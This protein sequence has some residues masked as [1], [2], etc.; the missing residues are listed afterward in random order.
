MFWKKKTNRKLDKLVFEKFLVVTNFHNAIKSRGDRKSCLALF[1]LLHMLPVSRGFYLWLDT[2]EPY[3]SY[4][5][6]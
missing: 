1:Y 6:D 5:I 3:I 4:W 2:I